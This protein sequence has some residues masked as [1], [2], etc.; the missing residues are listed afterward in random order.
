MQSRSLNAVVLAPVGTW[1]GLQAIETMLEGTGIPVV[2]QRTEGE[3]KGV[4]S[5]SA[6]SP[7]SVEAI[8]RAHERCVPPPLVRFRT[9]KH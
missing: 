7:A 2:P 6:D 1:R 5:N 4:A 9:P 8:R 3:S